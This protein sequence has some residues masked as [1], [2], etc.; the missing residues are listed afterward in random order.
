[1]AAD[2]PLEQLGPEDFQRFC[3]T[4]L[5]KDF[6]GFQ[7]FPIAQRDGGRDA[8]ARFLVDGRQ[9]HVVFQVKFVRDPQS[10]DSRDWL[11]RVLKSEAP[12]VG[13]LV[14]RGRATAYYLLTN[15]AGTSYPDS[16]SMDTIQNLL[17]A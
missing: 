6:P 5:V 17:D 12:K 11:E 16:G 10:K 2:Y 7:A 9:E 13:S 1:M 4:L 14:K 3:Q 8:T 15:V